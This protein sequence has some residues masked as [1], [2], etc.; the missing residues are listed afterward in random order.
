MSKPVAE[1]AVQHAG[2][3]TLDDFRGDRVT[4]SLFKVTKFTPSTNDITEYEVCLST[5]GDFCTCPAGTHHAGECKH[6]KMVREWIRNHPDEN[7]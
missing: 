4:G 2:T 7:T 6:L 1:Y 5:L 3:R